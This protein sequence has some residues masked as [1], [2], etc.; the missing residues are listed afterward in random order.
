MII[1]FILLFMKTLFSELK[2]LKPNLLIRTFLR[3]LY[4]ILTDCFNLYNVLFNLKI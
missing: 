1:T 2:H 3:I 4:Q